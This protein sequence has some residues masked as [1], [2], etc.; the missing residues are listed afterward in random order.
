MEVESPSLGT[1]QKLMKYGT[2]FFFSPE[3][4]LKSV[5]ACTVI[6]SLQASTAELCNVYNQRFVKKTKTKKTRLALKSRRNEPGSCWFLLC[7]CVFSDPDRLLVWICIFF[8]WNMFG[9]LICW[10]AFGSLPLSPQTVSTDDSASLSPL[11]SAPIFGN[12]SHVR[13]LVAAGSNLKGTNSIHCCC[14]FSD[15]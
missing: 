13:S 12:S 4:W 15:S 3:R 9:S 6:V 10:L 5:M 2:F 14:F 8:S 1:S 7:A 11:S